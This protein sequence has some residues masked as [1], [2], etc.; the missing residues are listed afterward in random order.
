MQA[1]VA[2]LS[3]ARRRSA[4]R[5]EVARAA[6]FELVPGGRRLAVDVESLGAYATA[7]AAHWLRDGVAPLVHAFIAGFG[8]VA[9]PS[10]LRLFA[11]AELRRLVCGEERID[12]DSASLLGCVLERGS[13]YGHDAVLSLLVEA[14]VG[15]GN[16]DRRE[17]LV[18]CTAKRSLPP[19][20]LREMASRKKIKVNVLSTCEA[21]VTMASLSAR[22]L[23][24]RLRRI[25]YRQEREGVGDVALDTSVLA[26]YDSAMEGGGD[27]ADTK[28][29]MV[30]E[31]SKHQG[32]LRSPNSRWVRSSPA[33]S[34]NAYW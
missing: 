6:A 31:L 23:A 4:E 29:A 22:Q 20:G 34:H 10:T 14:L 8:E 13:F 2:E 33:L 12:W 28:A 16:E 24:E 11:P 3:A 32:S 1:K 5:L 21:K 18:F 30:A 26:A 25:Q 27:V 17:F 9:P 19:G 15:M 7:L